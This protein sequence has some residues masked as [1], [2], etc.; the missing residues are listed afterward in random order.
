MTTNGP[1]KVAG[2]EGAS[3]MSTENGILGESIGAF[4]RLR[5]REQRIGLRAFAL[6]CEVLPTAMSR[7]LY[8]VLT[9]AKQ[10][11]DEKDLRRAVAKT[12]DEKRDSALGAKFRRLRAA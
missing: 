4:I 8:S 7:W 11:D 10:H 1:V 6:T 12:Q 3:D 9:R 2:D 5:R